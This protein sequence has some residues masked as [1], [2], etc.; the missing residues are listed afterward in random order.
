[1]V[2]QIV[3]ARVGR[4]I[5]KVNYDELAM[6]LIWRWKLLLVDESKDISVLS[7][8]IRKKKQK[9]YIVMTKGKVVP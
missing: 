2:C 7:L 5:F 3:C 8:G 1:M 9:K 6:S 4:R